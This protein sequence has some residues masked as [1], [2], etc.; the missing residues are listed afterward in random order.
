MRTHVACVAASVL[1]FAAIGT[2]AATASAQQVVYVQPAPRAVYVEG[3]GGD[4][5]RFRGAIDLTGGGLLVSGVSAGL[6]G[7]DA[8]LGVQVNNLLGIYAQPHLS[9]GAGTYAGPGNTGFTGV[10]GVSGIVDFTFDRVFFGGGGGFAYVGSLPFASPE[11]EIRAGFYPI[12]SH[13]RGGR[14][15]GLVIAAD[16]HILYVPDTVG[17]IGLLQPMLQIGYEAF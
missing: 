7:V 3:G 14:R 1:A 8:R 16:L 17:S 6:V 15:R 4:Y 13:G 12:V 9:F 2:T 10:A 11:G 5:A